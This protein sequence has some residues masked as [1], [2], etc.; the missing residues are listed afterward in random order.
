MKRQEIINNLKNLGDFAIIEVIPPL[1][2]YNH[3]ILL[4]LN[5]YFEKSIISYI[6]I[7]ICMHKV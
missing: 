5:N 1:Q 4:L 2:I 7:L 3:I 6:I